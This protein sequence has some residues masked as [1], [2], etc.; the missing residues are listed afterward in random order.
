MAALQRTTSNKLAKVLGARLRIA[1]RTFSARS[2]VPFEF[3]RIYALKSDSLLTAIQR[4]A[5][6]NGG[7]GAFKCGGVA[8]A[9]H[10]A[11]ST[12]ANQNSD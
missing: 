9:A 5:I 3:G 4:V 10:P 12:K 8:I 1:G 6:Q 2:A 7:T 11:E